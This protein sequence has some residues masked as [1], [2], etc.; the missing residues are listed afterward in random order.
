MEG[1]VKSLM[2]ALGVG[3]AMAWWNPVG[4]AA[5]TSEPDPGPAAA[6]AARAHPAVGRA[7]ATPRARLGAPVVRASADGSGGNGGQG[8]QGG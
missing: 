6:S 7:A 3:A 2:L 4:A 8:G 1:A 5:Q